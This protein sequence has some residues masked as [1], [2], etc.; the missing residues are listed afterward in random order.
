MANK[1]EVFV[2]SEGF[3]LYIIHL[4]MHLDIKKYGL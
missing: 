3:Q 4:F 1:K 2:Q